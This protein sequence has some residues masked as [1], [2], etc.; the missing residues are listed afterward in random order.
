[1]IAGLFMGDWEGEDAGIVAEKPLIVSYI[2]VSGAYWCLS[3][4]IGYGF[5]G[6]ILLIQTLVS[7]SAL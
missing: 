2:R 7:N 5:F 3:G 4:R 6:I 1:M